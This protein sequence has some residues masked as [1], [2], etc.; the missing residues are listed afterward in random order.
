MTF[1]RRP[2]VVRRASAIRAPGADSP[3]PASAVVGPGDRVQVTVA[4]C[5]E[6][7]VAVKLPS[8]DSGTI[9]RSEFRGEQP[10]AGASLNA[11]Y[12]LRDELD[13]VVLT[14]REPVESSWDQLRRGD[15]VAASVNEMNRGG[16]SLSVAGARGFSPLSQLG[17]GELETVPAQ[18]QRGRFVGEVV[19][20]DAKKKEVRL[21]L[22]SLLER[23]EDARRQGVFKQLDEGS[24]VEGKI[25]RLNQHGSF[26]DVGGVEGLLHV[27]KMLRH[28]KE[29][30][31]PVKFDVGETITV[32]I[33]QVDPSRGRVALGLPEDNKE[34]TSWVEQVADYQ[35]G[36]SVTG[37]VHDVRSDGCSVL[38]DEG[39]FGWVSLDQFAA[40]GVTPKKGTLV[41]ARVEGLD[42]ASRRV[43]LVL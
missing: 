37:L 39:V 31:K 13:R 43:T 28:V 15:L 27:S 1:K 16:L 2:I 20:V 33:L 12:L 11:L 17:R 26:I 30:E 40:S 14:T 6:F 8:G 24:M 42:E 29:A 9:E 19:A 32:E 23:R 34:P 4:E 7:D 36:E 41:Q 22:R 5:G 18:F 21:G 3:D 25:V 35:A 38:I 10:V